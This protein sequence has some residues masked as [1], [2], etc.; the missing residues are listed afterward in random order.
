VSAAGG[1]LMGT[2][3]AADAAAVLRTASSPA[4]ILP[5]RTQLRPLHS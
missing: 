2:V 4:A 1:L 5:A 3:R